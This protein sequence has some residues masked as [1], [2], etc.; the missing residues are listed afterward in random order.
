MAL[1][2][3]SSILLREMLIQG[4]ITNIEPLR[5]GVGEEAP[6]GSLIDL[7]VLRVNHGGRTIPVIP[8]SSLKGMF[9]STAT[10][11]LRSLQLKACSG[12]SKETC[13]DAKIP[14]QHDQ[15]SLGEAIKFLLKKGETSKAMELFYRNACL[16]CKIFGAPSYS[17]K[18][19]FSDAYPLGEDGE[20]L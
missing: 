11:I 16:L 12:L 4:Y 5:I 6:P 18:I 14:E 1:W 17:S 10:T 20:I 7:A 3:S 13:M 2:T 8:G 19:T 9:R 15:K